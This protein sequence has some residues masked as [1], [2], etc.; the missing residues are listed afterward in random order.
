MKTVEDAKPD[1]EGEAGLAGA[2]GKRRSLGRFEMG[3]NSKRVSAGIG[4]W[5]SEMQ[6]TDGGPEMDVS[7]DG[8]TTA[9][10]PSPM[11]LHSPGGAQELRGVD[12][13]KE[14]ESPK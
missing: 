8:Q 9:G 6:G 3:I 12:H 1:P 14:L 11:T 10:V 13:S 5:R 4:T 2:K 7:A